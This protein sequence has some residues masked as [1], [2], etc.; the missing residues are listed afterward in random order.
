MRQGSNGV[1]ASQ[2]EPG[3]KRKSSFNTLDERYPPNKRVQVLSD[4]D[5]TSN[6]IVETTVQPTKSHGFI[7][8]ELSRTWEPGDEERAWRLYSGKR[9]LRHVHS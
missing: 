2:A 6:T 9:P 7:G 5:D 3:K 4:Y 1:H 8:V